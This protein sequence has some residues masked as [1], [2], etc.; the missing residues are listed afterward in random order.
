[1][2]SLD[3]AALIT[4]I[5]AVVF[6]YFLGVI[7]MGDML[8]ALIFFFLTMWLVLPM[9]GLLL[10]PFVLIIHEMWVYHQPKKEAHQKTYPLTQD[11]PKMSKR[12]KQE[13]PS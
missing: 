4:T 1:M 3:I 7:V 11:S 8:S 9:T 10:I 6:N 12:L 2:N 13:L 5:L